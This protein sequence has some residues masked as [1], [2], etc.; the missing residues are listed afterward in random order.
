M[1]THF[2][3]APDKAHAYHRLILGQDQLARVDASERSLT[4]RVITDKGAPVHT[5]TI[6]SRR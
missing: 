2:P 4:V 5:F 3:R 1:T 6:P